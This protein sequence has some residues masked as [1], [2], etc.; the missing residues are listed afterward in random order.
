MSTPQQV[1]PIRVQA[2]AESIAGPHPPADAQTGS[3]NSASID[4]PDSDSL[5][6]KSTLCSGITCSLFPIYHLAPSRTSQNHTPPHLTN[7]PSQ[8]GVLKPI[9]LSSQTEVHTQ[10]HP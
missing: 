1:S 6:P 7:P 5:F 4:P 3:S 10:V 9:P 8:K 2:S